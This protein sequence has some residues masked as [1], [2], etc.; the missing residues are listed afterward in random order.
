M[1]DI[2]IIPVYA[3]DRNEAFRYS[4]VRTF[5]LLDNQADEIRLKDA[6]TRL[7]RN[8]WRKIGARLVGKTQEDPEP[9]DYHLPKQFADDY[10]LFRWSS[11]SYDK[12]IDDVIKTGF[13]P[14]PAEEGVT[15]WPS[16]NEFDTLFRP[17]SWPF[18]HR[19]APNLP[20][21][22]VHIT[23]FHDATVIAI[24][25]PHAFADQLGLSN[26]VKAW[27][28][29]L[30]GK[31]P[32]P[33]VGYDEDVLPGQKPFE[34]Y[35]KS[36]TYKKGR[37]H[38]RYFWEYFFVLLRFIPELVFHPKETKQLLFFPIEMVEKLRT[39]WTEDEELGKKFKEAGELTTADI[40]SGLLLK[41]S[42]IDHTS[43][44]MLS[45][46]QTVNLRNRTESLASPERA[47][48]FIHNALIWVT[49]Y[50]RYSSS[51]SVGELACRN[52]RAINTNLEPETSDL[53]VA[54]TREV[55]RTSQSMHIAEIGGFSFNVT[56]WAPVWRQLDFT[57]A[58]LGD[59]EGGKRKP[60]LLVFGD[61]RMPGVPERFHSIIMCR[62]QEGYYVTFVNRVKTVNA[63]KKYL[64]T[65]PLLQN[66]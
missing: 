17:S 45:F 26:I 37:M 64:E 7:I 53:M 40:L 58:V 49:D 28:G 19:E 47:Y 41:L 62:S 11:T 34:S 4:R 27:I 2:E 63:V 60:K 9:L 25:H 44:P 1:D 16:V 55:A 22:L 6:L 61:A 20:M 43:K 8:H 33:M 18:T 13:R 48:G 42:R 24:S 56:N 65:D 32:P 31:A 52:R 29:M 3:T 39:K 50:F 57:P 54:I 59:K 5:F 15:V 36:E 14:T 30:E 51:L 12:S 23:N 38:M 46:T 35:P 21:L 66:L 10:E